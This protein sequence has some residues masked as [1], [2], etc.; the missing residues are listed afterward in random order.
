[1]NDHSHREEPDLETELTTVK[2]ALEADD[3]THGAHHLAAAMAVGAGDPRVKNL[4]LR[5]SE[6]AAALEQDPL[7][8]FVLE[9]TAFHGTVVC[10]AHFLRKAGE[11]E[12]ALWLI[13]QAMV[14]RPESNYE[15]LLSEFDPDTL[16]P[17]GMMRCLKFYFDHVEPEAQTDAGA[18]LLALGRSAAAQNPDNESLWFLTCIFVRRSGQPEEAA[19][20]AEARMAQSPTSMVAVALAG[21][22]R[23]SG[24]LEAAI[25]AFQKGAELDP[26]NLSLYLDIGDLHLELEQ[27]EESAAAYQHVLDQDPEHPWALPSLM[28]CQQ[29]MGDEEKRTELEALAEAGN[30]RAV[31]IL[32]EDDVAWVD[33]LPVRRDAIVNVAR[34]ISDE[35]EPGAELSDI[36]LSAVEAPSAVIAFERALDRAGIGFGQVVINVEDGSGDAR[37]GPGAEGIKLFP[38]WNYEGN[39]AIAV[40]PVPDEKLV[41]AVLTIALSP[42][43]P[44]QWWARGFTLEASA[45]ELAGALAHLPSDALIDEVS[46]EEDIDIPEVFFHYQVAITYALAAHP[47]RRDI[48]MQIALGPVD[49]TTTAALGALAE[50]AE[51]EPVEKE[52]FFS[53]CRAWLSQPMSSAV[54]QHG[55]EPVA[56]LLAQCE[57]ELTPDLDGFVDHFFSEE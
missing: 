48:L 10:H 31:D 16:D 1:M 23:E 41:R 51:R 34:Q 37:I 15:A 52:R 46:G 55:I 53:I 29:L 19:R 36:T 14:A 27:L 44:E 43:D 50:F 45:E 42:F 30:D 57:V 24:D 18:H 9:E 54:F 17:E 2:T 25:V 7:V 6:R 32:S 21:A 13:T 56:L 35:A 33:Y 4:L 28:R 39:Q 12:P 49:W 5:F 22:H 47:A 38:I 8:L 20:M 3:L 26:E 11:I 40:Q